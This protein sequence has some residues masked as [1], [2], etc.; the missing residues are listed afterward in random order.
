MSGD[1]ARNLGGS[2]DTFTRILGLIYTYRAGQV[3]ST[4]I[5]RK[6]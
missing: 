3:Y 1:D 2:G 6:V 4:G 5:E